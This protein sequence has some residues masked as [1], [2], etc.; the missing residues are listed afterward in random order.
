[1]TDWD[2]EES[3]IR[4]EEEEVEK[5]SDEDVEIESNEQG[6]EP[7][8]IDAVMEEMQKTKKIADING[9]TDSFQQ[10]GLLS[11]LSKSQRV[12]CYRSGIPRF[13]IVIDF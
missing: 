11:R 1:M 3:K 2:S 12:A 8:D 5:L 4:Q 13:A 7:F 9:L 6:E 10:L